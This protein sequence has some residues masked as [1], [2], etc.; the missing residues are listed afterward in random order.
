VTRAAALDWARRLVLGEPELAPW[1]PGLARVIC[2]CGL[3]WFT[4]SCAADLNPPGPEIPG[5][6]FGQ[7]GSQPRARA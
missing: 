5:I 2:R 4:C 7:F 3:P 1:P 6:A